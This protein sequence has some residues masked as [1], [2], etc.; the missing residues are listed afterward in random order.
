MIRSR[1]ARRR[2]RAVL[3]M[4]GVKGPPIDI[5]RVA[6]QL[7]FEVHRENFPENTSAV[8]VVEGDIR[9]IGVNRNHA[10]VRQRF[11][12]AH[13]LGHYLQGHGDFAD[14]RKTFE[15]GSYDYSDPQ[16]R[17]EMEANEFAAELLMPESLLRKDVTNMGLDAPRLAK[18][19][20]V[21]E[22]AMWIQLINLHI[23]SEER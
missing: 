23:V 4:I 3:N 16:N 12:I 10:L 22:Q 14:S 11:S 17:Q 9:A 19:Y 6:K 18:R 5:E 8:L 21:S 13:E 7:G 20:E 1:E 2:A 15:D